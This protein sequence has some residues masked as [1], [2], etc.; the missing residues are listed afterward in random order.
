M[1]GVRGLL[2]DKPWVRGRIHDV[3]PD[4]MCTDVSITRMAATSVPVNL[5]NAWIRARAVYRC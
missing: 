1:S 2:H 5:Y 3:E 4:V